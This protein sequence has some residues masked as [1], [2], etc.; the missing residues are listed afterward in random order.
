[1]ND[2]EINDIR[3][4]KHFK[5]VSFSEFKK[6]DVKKE[7]I[8]SLQKAKIEP[9]CYW[10]AELVCSGHYLEL[11]DIIITFVSKYIHL[12]NPKL[13]LYIEMRYESFKSIISSCD[14]LFTCNNYSRW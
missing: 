3:E 1:M 4:Q 12:A 14:L 10:S 11:W 7:L 5:G 9:A 13:P 2:N 6:S 8:V